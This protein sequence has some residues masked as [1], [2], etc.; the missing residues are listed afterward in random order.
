MVAL[1]NELD[2]T[3][4]LTSDQ[5]QANVDEIEKL[6][7]QVQAIGQQI[8][9]G[10]NSD[11]DKT[12]ARSILARTSLLAA[13][14]TRR[15]GNDPQRVLQ[16]LDGFEDRVAGLPSAQ[17]L[18]NGALFL[19]VQSYMQLGR[20]NDATKTLVEY[21]SGTE[22]SEG[23]QT[24]HDLLAVLN[25]DLDW[26]SA[27]ADAAA[28]RHDSTAQAAAQQSMIQLAANRAMLSGFLVQWATDSSD[29]KI[30][31]YAYTYRR[32]DADAKRTAAELEPD[33]GKR[34]EE[35]AEVMVLYK[36]LQTPEDLALYRATAEGEGGADPNEPDPLVTL[37]IGLTA[38][39]LGD[40]QTVKQDLG[41]LIHDQKLGDDNDQ[42]WEAT[43]KLLD[44]MHTL[45]KNGDPNTTDAQVQQSLKILYLIWHDGTGGP[46]W[47][48]KFEALR[49]EV[50]PDWTVPTANDATQGS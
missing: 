40:C 34:K 14:I 30:R 22:G 17:Q 41:S 13:D 20:N 39:D 37:G 15:E 19:R 47:H 4:K 6:A 26:T 18:L 1:K 43:Y 5:R 21:L 11:H 45:A 23:A 9:S 42:Y 49:K 32:F 8:V 35:L 31:A 12:E 2:E 7:N 46:K 50:L 29:P 24:V 36:Q 44:C 25:R 33:A 28:A 48:G 38:Y 3:D 10:S 27:K 16:L